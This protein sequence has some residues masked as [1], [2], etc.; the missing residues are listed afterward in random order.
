VLWVAVVD[1]GDNGVYGGG[2]GCWLWLMVVILI[3]FMVV[4]VVV[5][6]VVVDGGVGAYGGGLSLTFQVR[7]KAHLVIELT[8]S[9]PHSL[10]G[11]WHNCLQ[12]P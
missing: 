2:G 4:V 10:P 7:G 6:A 12:R 8:A 1:G 9:V 11:H 3:V 5:V